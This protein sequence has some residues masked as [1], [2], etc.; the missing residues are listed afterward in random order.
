[1]SSFQERRL[2][3]MSHTLFFCSVQ[4]AAKKTPLHLM[5]TEEDERKEQEEE[6]RQ[7]KIIEEE[8]A[9]LKGAEKGTTEQGTS[10]QGT[11]EQ[12][13]SEQS[14]S[15]QSTSE[16][17]TSEQGTSQQGTSQQ[18]TSSQLVPKK[19]EPAFFT[20]REIFDVPPTWC[21]LSECRLSM[22]VCKNKPAGCHKQWRLLIIHECMLQIFDDENEQSAIYIDDKWK[23]QYLATIA[24]RKEGK[25]PILRSYPPKYKFRPTYEDI[26]AKLKTWFGFEVCDDNE[27][28]PHQFAHFA[29][30]DP[31]GNADPQKFLLYGKVALEEDFDEEKEIIQKKRNEEEEMDDEEMEEEMEDEEEDEMEG[32]EQE[33]EEI[34]EKEEAEG[35]EEEGGEEV[36]EDEKKE[37]D[38]DG[39]EEEAVEGEEDQDMEKEAEGN[40]EEE[41]EETREM[42]E[43]EGHKEEEQDAEIA[44][45]LEKE[46]D[47]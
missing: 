32:E 26:W 1:M 28:V 22:L 47:D 42:E 46:S 11:S 23:D 30:F 13:T 29:D 33:E 25:D 4:E 39:E 2:R 10:E 18:G 36:E 38:Q 5:F 20:W 44:A 19:K 40:Q 6:E 12:S 34:E 35:E 3:E 7:R 27:P 45:G 31:F 41:K 15:E 8:L 14:T 24:A 9:N 17:S 37:E 43:E 16:Q 21:T